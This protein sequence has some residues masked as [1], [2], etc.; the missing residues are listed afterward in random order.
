MSDSDLFNHL[1]GIL[2]EYRRISDLPIAS[3]LLHKLSMFVLD[4]SLERVRSATSLDNVISCIKS[5]AILLYTHYMDTAVPEPIASLIGIKHI[6]NTTDVVEIKRTSNHNTILANISDVST[7]T[8]AH[9]PVI[10]NKSFSLPLLLHEEVPIAFMTQVELGQV[11]SIF[12]DLNWACFNQ[13][14]KNVIKYHHLWI[15]P[16]TFSRVGIATTNDLMARELQPFIEQTNISVDRVPI[17]TKNCVLNERCC[18]HL[19]NALIKAR[20]YFRTSQYPIIT[21]DSGLSI[22]ALG[23]LPGVRTETYRNSGKGPNEILKEM[24]TIKDRGAT[25]DQAQML[26][27]II[28]D[29]GS[30]CEVFVFQFT[31]IPVQIAKYIKGDSLHPFDNII[32][33]PFYKKY[34][35]DISL[36]E[37]AKIPERSYGIRDIARY[38]ES[39]NFD[40]TFSTPSTNK[41]AFLTGDIT[42]DHYVFEADTG[43]EDVGKYVRRYQGISNSIRPI[44]YFGGIAVLNKL[45]DKL[46]QGTDLILKL[47]EDV[48]RVIQGG[49][50]WNYINN[51]ST[52]DSRRFNLKIFRLFLRPILPESKDLVFRVK[53]LISSF[54]VF[55]KLRT[56]DKQIEDVVDESSVAITEFGLDGF[57]DPYDLIS[58]LNGKDSV[59]TLFLKTNRPL[60]FI[61]AFVK[62]EGLRYCSNVVLLC[63]SD[64]IFSSYIPNDTFRSWEALICTLTE[65]FSNVNFDLV[66]HTEFWIV[67]LCK[68]EGCIL[69]RPKHGSIFISANVD[70]NYL[71][72]E[73]SGSEV[74]RVAGLS[75]VFFSKL[76]NDIL[77]N[78]AP[79][80]DM[81]EAVRDAWCL[82]R[83]ISLVGFGEFNKQGQS[84]MFGLNDQI[85]SYQTLKKSIATDLKYSQLKNRIGDFSTWNFKY[86]QKK[87]GAI[88]DITEAKI[89]DKEQ[90]PQTHGFFYNGGYHRN[91]DF[92]EFSSTGISSE[93][94][95]EI[96]L[97]IIQNGTSILKKDMSIDGR[98]IRFFMLSIGKLFAVRRDD[99]ERLSYLYQLI[100]DYTQ[101]QKVFRPL[102]IAVFGKPGS[103]KSFTVKEIITSLKIET[104]FIEFN[105]SQMKDQ[106]DL[107]LAFHNVQTAALKGKL[108]V[109]FWDEFDSRFEKE[110]FG[111]LKYFLSPMQDGKFQVQGQNHHFGKVIFAFAGGTTETI[112]GFMDILKDN[113][114]KVKELK[115]PD[116]RSRIKSMY[117]VP[118][119]DFD[120]D[121]N[122]TDRLSTVIQR[123]AIIRHLFAL[124]I[125]HI[126]TI[127]A[128][129]VLKLLTCHFKSG[130]RSIES[131][132]ESS[133]LANEVT[134]SLRNFPESEQF[135]AH[136]KEANKHFDITDDRYRKRLIYLID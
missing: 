31:R 12:I 44:G 104:E 82:S 133:T 58:A 36:S 105:L 24:E 120:T 21:Q 97:Q 25:I 74:G 124:H 77:T 38:I 110:E 33:V 130:I 41:K 60:A 65:A 89:P 90:Q 46:A 49:N 108:P 85:S 3:K 100:K 57:Q 59:N 27:W 45:L 17:T 93:Q 123:A 56:I 4:N 42:Y 98:I 114:G 99:V 5:G 16:S 50:G 70:K 117:D 78:V 22:N 14:L 103:G 55:I 64:N 125:P 91:I 37:K 54:P 107:L 67:A 126:Q 109:V 43:F 136:I 32:Y 129:V 81:G 68:N 62:G 80:L 9:I 76:I 23:G 53:N 40:F 131:I 135:Y 26:Y 20:K 30:Q 48:E 47:P 92:F 11:I 34:L 95:I 39:R 73:C 69:L 6:I 19:E 52:A 51:T 106:Q 10:E 18:S 132:I 115:I 13:F 1:P 15:K 29:D 79:A 128:D 28:D 119:V 63:N 94:I 134:Y 86:T 116:F 87:S 111:W 127:E 88:L 72:G 113:P 102:S 8:T 75:G 83:Y 121:G 112:A 101:R 66:S 122:S 2:D 71:Y 35:S 84:I 118:G 96:G 7:S 61:D